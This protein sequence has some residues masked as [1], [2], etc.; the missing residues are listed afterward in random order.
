MKRFFSVSIL[1]AVAFA[2]VCE[3]SVLLDLTSRTEYDKCV[4]TSAMDDGPY[5]SFSVGSG[6]R[7]DFYSY[8]YFEDYLTSP[9][10]DL[11]P[12]SLYVVETA[13]SKTMRDGRN[14]E[15]VILLGK[16]YAPSTELSAL[17]GYTEIGRV[18]P[19]PYLTTDQIADNVQ[20]FTFSVS[21]PGKYRVS[22]RGVVRTI[23]YQTRILEMGQS[24]Q[25]QK[26]SDLRL[27]PSA[28]GTVAI[29][30]TMP[31]TTVSGN[32]LPMK[33]KYNLY[34]GEQAIRSRSAAPGEFIEYVH[35]AAP[36]GDAIYSVE[37][38]NGEAV[39]ERVSQTTFVGT[40]T[41]LPPTNV[42]FA[43]DDNGYN[44]TWTPQLKGVHGATLDAAAV[45]Y[46]VYRIVDGVSTAVAT[47][48]KDVNSYTDSYVPSALV[49]LSY[50]V[51]AHLGEQASEIAYATTR[52]EGIMSLPFADSFAGGTLSN[53]WTTE[54]IAGTNTEN[55][56]AMTS[57]TTGKPLAEP[58]DGDGGLAY[59][60][61]FNIQKNKS[62]RLV[63]VP[64]SLASGK[65]P[66]LSFYMNHHT[67]GND[68]LRIQVSSDGGE[69]VDVE[70]A[71]FNPKSDPTGWTKHDVGLASAIA[72]EASSFRVAFLAESDYGFNIVIDN[73]RIFNLSAKDLAV[74]SF[75]APA[76]VI[77]GNDIVLKAKIA[78]QGGAVAQPD[79]YSI[80]LETD[81]PGEVVL[82]EALAIPSLSEREIAITIPV[83]SFHLTEQ[84]IFNFKLKLIYA[85]DLEEGNNNSA[86]QTVS[87]VYGA[88]E[89]VADLVLSDETASSALL[90]WQPTS[91]ATYVPMNISESFESFTKGNTDELNGWTVVDLD[92][93]E[94]STH[95]S[96]SG[97]KLAVTE[98]WTNVP[99][100]LDGSK[101]LAVTVK[102]YVE[103]DDWLISPAFT[104]AEGATADLA[105]KVGYKSSSN[106]GGYYLLEVRYAET[107][108][109]AANPIAAFTNVVKTWKTTGNY[110]VLKPDQTMRDVVAS[111]IPSTAK[112][113]AV[114]FNS[115][116]NYD[117]A[118][119]LDDIRLTEN[120]ANPMRGYNVYSMIQGKLNDTILAP[121]TTSFEIKRATRSTDA[122]RYFVSAV[123]ADGEAAPSA[124]VTSSYT[125]VES[126]TV[127]GF[128][129]VYD[130]SGRYV[131]K[132]TAQLPA[133]IYL[134]QSSTETRKLLVR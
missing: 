74:A 20:R 108:F 56:K 47:G 29:S 37:I 60:N 97:S 63:T 83:N 24:D 120:I 128:V 38:V 123:Y 39:S 16:G 92:R 1:A 121:M 4:T 70:G 52:A 42:A 17:T 124:C 86:L 18:D 2:A 112:Y 125:G 76:T 73:V 114:R 107:D 90:T 26:V 54:I 36:A 11:S 93:K 94:G 106:I 30:F 59:Y 10:L 12:G 41:P 5:W 95:Y 14:G 22:F 69:W 49:Q 31:N 130:L 67:M 8:E 96:A 57:L 116:A 80:E 40:E 62:A 71:L 28:D 9:E 113:V 19:I 105:L 131:G 3:E 15:L 78:N 13:P 6:P 53:L 48:L 127:D 98:A 132:N 46:T 115:K 89:T 75:E 82:P 43:K 64:I 25:P 58:Q 84:N 23:L 133:G 118:M 79:E 102:G 33:L 68:R 77:A 45:S 110:D 134:I 50:G 87:A 88:G 81:F 27:V 109:D 34:C 51:S 99:T 55:W 101:C 117:L 122:E 44:I 126:V 66:V 21:E 7:L 65:N 85:G 35:T 111:G 61:S 32:P 91:D 103:Q 119:W 104:I 129:N 72:P 100:G